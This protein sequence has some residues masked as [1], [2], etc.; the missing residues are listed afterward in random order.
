VEGCAQ[1]HLPC[2]LAQDVLQDVAP[3]LAH[4]GILLAQLLTRCKGE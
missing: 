1:L 3:L 2:S 4:A